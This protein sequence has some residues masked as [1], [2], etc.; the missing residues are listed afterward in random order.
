MFH[1]LIVGGGIA[2]FNLARQLTERQRTFM[3]ID[4]GTENA[5]LASAGVYNPVILKRFTLAWKAA[6]FLDYALLQYRRTEMENGKRYLF[7]L[8][9]LRKLTSTAEQNDWETSSGRPGFERFMEGISFENI[10]GIEAPFGFGVMKN[11]GLLHTEKLLSDWKNGLKRIGRLIKEQFDYEQLN[12]K[13][14]Y[15][16]YKGIRAR[17]IIFSEGFGMKNNPFFKHLPMTGTKGETLI[18][19]LSKPVDKIVKSNIFLAPYPETD[20]HITGATYEWADKTWKPTVKAKTVLQE[21]LNGLY[22]EPY[23]IVAQK[24]GIR[25]TVKDRRPLLGK[26]SVYPQLSVF[27][28]LGTRGIIL[29]PSLAKIFLDH[30]EFDM[31]LLPE[32]D[33]RRFS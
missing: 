26:H 4:R 1:Y 30:L 6:E 17:H 18:V 3:L 31:P 16:E 24:A 13:E 29:A 21:K 22:L 11:T 7:P 20:L 10:P 33:I 25:P 19:K 23:E 12:I 32:T 28:G 14:N 9:I 5:T 27:N 2:G 15:V 8:P